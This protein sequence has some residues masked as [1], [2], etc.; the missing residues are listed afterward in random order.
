[1]QRYKKSIN[2]VLIIFPYLSK[3]TKIWELLENSKY[4]LKY[5][6]K[7][8]LTYKF[9]VSQPHFKVYILKNTYFI[10]TFIQIFNDF[11]F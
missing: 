6:Q 8:I 10:F 4:I 1:M 9:N 2:L 7:Y 11:H 5:I 3:M